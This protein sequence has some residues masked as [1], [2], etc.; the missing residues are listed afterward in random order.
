MAFARAY[1]AQLTMAT[2]LMYTG[3]K[4]LW[5][6][7]TAHIQRFYIAPALGRMSY[8][9]RACAPFLDRGLSSFTV[10]FKFESQHQET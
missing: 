4:Y 8:L 3:K 7:S 9:E 5:S 10:K 2:A 1:T 6:R